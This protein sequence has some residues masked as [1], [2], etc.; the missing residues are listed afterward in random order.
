MSLAISLGS[1]AEG[2]AGASQAK[3]D[4]KE[5][6]DAS[7]QK[8]RYLDIMEKN[9]G[10]FMGS[11]QGGMGAM[12]GQGGIPANGGAVVAATMPTKVEAAY[13]RDGLIK[14][15]MPPHIADGF[16]LNFKDES[17][18]NTSAVGDGGNAIGLAQWNGPRMQSLQ[19]FSKERGVPHSD[20]DA[21][22]DYLM[23][24]LQG[25]EAGAWKKIQAAN[26]AG[27]AAAAIVNHFERPAEKH[28]ARREQSYLAYGAG[29]V[30]MGARAP[31][32]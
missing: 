31:A 19:A 23:H 30:A 6:A 21:Q 12:P 5:R 10:L 32:Y 29:P 20:A 24:E 14:R 27:S 18:F 2:F 7:A 26:N 3:K 15:G 16:V 25:P 8:D 4:R 1:F 17:G 13:V 22:M 11:A 28:R 9:P